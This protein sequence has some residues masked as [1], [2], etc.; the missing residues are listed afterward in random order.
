M[1]IL[2]VLSYLRMIYNN[3]L[4]F[5]QLGMGFMRHDV[6]NFGKTQELVDYAMTHGVNYF[7]AC[8]FYLNRKCESVVGKA[9]AKYPRDSYYIC[10]KYDI[11]GYH[12]PMEKL[13]NFFNNQLQ[14]CG[15][16]YF[17]VYL[18]QA[19][20][21]K[22]VNN[23]Q[24]VYEFFL[25]KKAEGKI[26]MLGFSFHDTEEILLQYLEGRQ[27]DICQIQLNYYDWYLGEGKK[28]YNVLA[29]RN[30]PIITMGPFKGGTLTVRQPMAVQNHFGMPYLSHL[31]MHFLQTLPQVKVILTGAEHFDMLQQNI[32]LIDNYSFTQRDKENCQK[33]IKIYQ[34]INTIECGG[35]RYCEPGCPKHIPIAQTLQTYNKLLLNPEDKATRE[36]F[37]ILSKSSVSFF[38]CI[39]CRQCDNRCPQHLPI[40]AYFFNQLFTAR[41]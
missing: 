28:L 38:D 14:T 22:S 7:E 31:A 30:I 32:D 37:T 24:K 17:D 33:I 3:D 4:K 23:I 39:G 16:D 5:S 40:S 41:L 35:C 6:N 20:D 15:V 18:L 9:L 10:D 12:L 27:W 21:R 26:K 25:K 8:S 1:I 36:Q 2:L 19:L 29:S 13:E 34:Q 11:Y